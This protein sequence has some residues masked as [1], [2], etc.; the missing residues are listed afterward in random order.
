MEKYCFSDIQMQ[1]IQKTLVPLAI[2]QFI[3]KRVVTVGLSEGFCKLFG[4]T[5]FETAY[6]EMDNDMYKDAYHDDIAR[7]ADAAL[8]FATLDEPYDVIYRTATKE[9]NGFKIIH[10]KGVHFEPVKGVK[11]ALV[12]Y[13][14][15]G[16]Y[17]EREDAPDVLL[18]KSLNNA[19]FEDSFIKA[20]Y[21]DHL[22]GM[23]SM[24]YFYEL[25]TLKRSEMEKQCDAPAL[26][27]MDFGGM[28][29]FNHKFGF[30]AG[31]SLLMSFSRLLAGYFGNEN[32]CRLG[33]DHFAVITSANRL[34]GN[35]RKLF[36]EC[37]MLNGGNSL[38][39]HVGIYLH[40]SEGIVASMACD[41]AKIACD[42][43][44]GEY[45]S[46]F[47][48]YDISMKDAEER[49]QYIIAN[50]D[51]AIAERW[52]KVYYQPIVRAVNGRV[53]DEEALARWI[54]PVKGFLSPGE[55]IPIL[56]EHSLIYK[57]DL[58]IV[59][60]V[61]KKIK[62]LTKAG[63]HIMPQSVNLS[64]SDFDSCDIVEEIRRRVD[65]SGI[66]RSMLTIE[67]TESVIGKDLDFMKTQIDRFRALGFAVWMDDF[68]SGYSSLDFLQE[69]SFDLIKFDMRFMQRFDVNRSAKIILTELLKMATSLGIDT[70]CEGVETEEQVKFLQEA[71]CSKLQG[72]F[73][74]KPIP[75]E[76]ILE[77]YNK[78]IQIGFEDPRESRY[79]ET[80]GRVNLHDLSVIAREPSS[81]FNNIFN[82][83]PMAIVELND[84]Q[85]RFARSNQS[86][87]DFIKRSFGFHVTDKPDLFTMSEREKMTTFVSDLRAAL[88]SN[89][90][91]FVY[92][93]LP[94]GTNV[95]A[96]IRKLAH[97]E[98]AN[99]YAVAVAVLSVTD[100]SQGASYESIAKALAADYFSLY[101]V[102][103]VTDK[104]YEY[105]S[106]ENDYELAT[107]RVS[108]DF[109]ARSIKDALKLIYEEDRIIFCE[110]FT[111]ERIL[112]EI[113]EYGTFTLTYRLM[114]N[115]EPVYVHMKARRMQNDPD[116]IIIG[117][118]NV[119]AQ[120]KQRVM[121]ENIRRNERIFSR[122]MAL[123]GEYIA[124]YM[125]DP[126]TDGF[127]EYSASGEF[128]A[129][130]LNKDG[131]DFFERSYINS[132]GIVVPEDR[133]RFINEFTKE[134]VMEQLDAGS[135]FTLY[136]SIFLDGVK[137]PV[138]LK[139]T[140]IR[141]DGGEKL[142]IGIAKVN[143][144]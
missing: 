118:S 45:A 40:W 86:Y 101:Y 127:V 16:M 72:F 62:I 142:L 94:N 53:C 74:E 24:T 52:I 58:Y 54:D 103:I 93:T 128:R 121:L 10:A 114:M 35:L 8:R 140:R 23:P 85:V 76:K 30:A 82:T 133:Q 73:F 31:D 126:V 49:Q 135:I 38:P 120:M 115:G 83:L 18:D 87:R 144:V 64:R 119:D 132:D 1:M 3:N 2:Y 55:F 20:S 36:D 68:G 67:I 22:T 137:T 100:S 44:R 7:I 57:L 96:C 47:S 88:N 139:G 117:V 113:N 34:E 108:D 37:K 42:T 13:T 50:I 33:Q 14:D 112:K 4:Y 110:A 111:K 131:I 81:E 99:T 69:I 70:I 78:G 92:E 124:M 56:E 106:D 48:Y 39:L 25:A 129:Y 63:L 9:N 65:K 19:L 21:F 89:E 28:K 104:F 90:T 17:T 91:R 43:L 125:V 143:G 122:I 123:S 26:L 79:Y 138:V 98:I 80:I 6:Y 11:L 12:W 95:R 41:R 77:K 51:K 75:V 66:D 84:K 130:G 32:C 61:L 136:Y 46:A 105:A 141:E 59:E 134:K 5:D 116:H 71:G 102:D 60:N 107:E 109:F 27:F 29:Y 97:N 15:E